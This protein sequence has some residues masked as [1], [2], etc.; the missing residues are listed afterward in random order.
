MKKVLLTLA[1]IAV[2]FFTTAQNSDK[3]V[4]TEVNIIKTEIAA[5]KKT[6]KI[7]IN[8]LEQTNLNF[9]KSNDI[10][11]IKA[12]TKS[13]QIKGEIAINS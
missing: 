8:P 2:P 4:K 7:S 5:K 11:S 6:E 9:K 3:I 1:I 10:I 12:Y 13:L